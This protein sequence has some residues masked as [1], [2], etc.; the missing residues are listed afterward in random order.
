M[1]ISTLIVD[2]E[3]LAR[4]RLRLLLQGEPDI[5]V[6]GECANGAEALEVAR[7]ETPAL[8]FLDVQMPKLDGFGLLAALPPG[9]I[10]AI[11]FVTA[12]D[13]HAVRAFEVSATDYL[14]KPL[15]A[16]R[17]REALQRARR[18]LQA[19]DASRL[20]D[21]LQALLQAAR[22]E[23]AYPSQLSIKNGERTVFVRVNDIDYIEAAAN[24]AILH[25]GQQSHILRDTLT[26]LETRLPPKYFL[27]VQRSFIVNLARV[28]GV[29]PAIRGEHILALKN[30]KELPMTRGVR[31]IQQRLEYL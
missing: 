1:K 12:Y 7:R 16:A 9:T 2:D 4:Q 28:T 24:Y 26:N 29:R 8:M 31:D 19:R 10:P 5:T 25:V 6:I 20:N 17:F 30:G 3:P 23:G 22:P 18:Q 11:I 14:L 15:K 27:R 13:R 21:R